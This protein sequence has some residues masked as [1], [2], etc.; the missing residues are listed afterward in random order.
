MQAGSL[1]QRLR[2]FVQKAP[3]CQ[4]PGVGYVIN[5]DQSFNLDVMSSSSNGVGSLG[6]QSSS[7]GVPADSPT[8]VIDFFEACQ[9]SGS[10]SE[11]IAQGKQ[12]ESQTRVPAVRRQGSGGFGEA[13][14][15]GIYWLI[16]AVVLVC[17]A[18]GSLASE[19]GSPPLKAR[20]RDGQTRPAALAEARLSHR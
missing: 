3:S 14:E 16:W 5:T 4:N 10:E 1:E 2:H 19:I 12:S 18:W 13:V 9:R 15:Q 8:D 11:R 20:D 7:N 17:L 6:H